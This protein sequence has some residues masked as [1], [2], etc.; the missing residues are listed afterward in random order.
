ME[1]ASDERTK[2]AENRR[3]ARLLHEKLAAS[4]NER[5]PAQLVAQTLGLP[6]NS[7]Y[8]RLNGTVGFSLGEWVTLA[9]ACGFSLDEL[10]GEHPAPTAPSSVTL[11]M[12]H[13][14]G[15]MK[16]YLRRLE[17]LSDHLRGLQGGERQ[18]AVFTCKHL[19]VQCYAPYPSLNRYM[20]FRSL[21]L[22][23]NGSHNLTLSKVT[24]DSAIQ[25]LQAQ[26]TEQLAATELAEYIV[27]SAIFSQ[28]VD[29]IG[30]FHSMELI[31]TEDKV[32]LK[33]ELLEM[34]GRMRTLTDRGINTQG[35]KT[36]V[37]VS[38][39]D[40]GSN[41][42]LFD[43]TDYHACLVDPFMLEEITSGHPE[44][45]RSAASWVQSIKRASCMIS[46]CDEK[47]RIRFFQ[48]QTEIVSSL[49]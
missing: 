45:C 7:A 9:K 48:R 26:I 3:F 23:E 39:L 24:V 32:R 17:A 27:D 16:G 6:L 29:E 8:R 34:L 20:I 15:A 5:R 4:G 12:P 40:L 2:S 1:A 41:L 31:E 33:Q 47:S 18:R 35:N 44:V 49:E 13:G 21:Y 22:R 14:K 19:P 30:F 28:L 25:L 42:A 36:T 37:Y 43:S 10:L 38:H 46:E 11:A